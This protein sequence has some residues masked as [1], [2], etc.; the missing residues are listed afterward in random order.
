M[1]KKSKPK[2]TRKPKLLPAPKN[3]S[4]NPIDLNPQELISMA[5]SSGSIDALERVLAMRDKLR[6]E[7]AETAYREAM[8][9]FQAEC[10]VIEKKAIVRNKPSSP[11]GTG[12]E[13]YRYASIEDIIRVVQPY[14]DKNNL[15]YKFETIPLKDTQEFIISTRAY[16][17]MG[18][19]EESSITLPVDSNEYMGIIHQRE[20]TQSYGKRLS[21]C[22]VFGIITGGVDNNAEPVD[23]PDVDKIFNEAKRDF[24][25][26]K[27]VKELTD[28]GV[29]HQ[30]NKVYLPKAKVTELAKLFND[31]M[32][33]FMEKE[34]K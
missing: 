7:A 2:A 1:N 18:H 9:R 27:T 24:G 17:I 16:H 33:E 31:K 15:S 25:M 34:K 21:F 5:I 8:S 22:N 10:P 12:T 23:I 6:K 26:A 29:K 11:G 14:L 30:E 4:S 3:L 13:R 32:N 28:F 19:C 20:S